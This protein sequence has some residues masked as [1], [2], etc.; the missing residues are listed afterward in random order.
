[1]NYTF[2]H[3]D[4]TVAVVSFD[5]YTGQVTTFSVVNPE[6]MPTGVSPVGCGEFRKWWKY[7]AVPFSRSTTKFPY[8]FGQ[9]FNPCA[10]LRDN[11]GV[12]LGD[13]Y[14]VC[15]EEMDFR[16]E[17]VSPFNTSDWRDFDPNAALGGDQD[18]RWLLSDGKPYLY[19]IGA[20]EAVNEY[21]ASE[22][23]RRQGFG[24][25][26]PYCLSEVCP[27]LSERTAEGEGFTA[28]VCAPFTSGDVEYVPAWQVVNTRKQGNSTSNFEHILDCAEACGMDREKVREFLE[29]QTITDFI[30]TNIDRHYTN[31]GFLRDS[32]TLRFLG[33]APIFDTGNS[34]FFEPD[35][36]L[37]PVR[38]E[39][40]FKIKTN[41][42]FRNEYKGL[43]VVRNCSV[44]FEKLMSY[45]EVKD[46]Y[47]KGGVDA[48]TADIIAGNYRSKIKICKNFFETGW[49]MKKTEQ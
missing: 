42:I 9:A 12:S 23:H 49:K 19:K 30:F 5:S 46:A 36:H 32:K 13:C 31:F 28:C 26:V 1:M 29:Y 3:R 15:P 45:E 10:Y 22:T 17:E 2:K 37:R 44:D 47:V 27:G 7:R 48:K 4:D 35:S 41:G 8:N 20:Y 38:Y 33:P 43:G 34:M 40:L 16:W 24:H 14:W 18:K 21:I 6:L 39:E 11:F 25:Y